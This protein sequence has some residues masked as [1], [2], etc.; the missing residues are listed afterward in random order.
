MTATSPLFNPFPGLRPFREDETHLF[1]GRDVQ[2]DELLAELGRCRFVA[3]M[4]ASGSGKSSL[5]TAGLLPALQGGLSPRL[6]ANWRIASLRPGGDPVRNLARVLVEPE[7]LVR[8]G[9]DETRAVDQTEALLRRSGLG[10]ADL[11]RRDESLRGGRLLVVVDQFEELFRFQDAG[12]RAADGA[13]N[14]AF[15]RLLIEAAADESNVS[16]I[17]TMRSD[18]LG[19]CSQF[20]QLPETINQGLYLVP[21]LTRTQLR[22]AITG[23]V[24]VGGGTIAP[25]LVQRLL[26]DAGADPDQLP[27]L[28]H[29]LMRMWN[30]WTEG[31]TGPGPI[32]L[33][34]Y[35][36]AGGLEHSLAWHAD[37]AYQELA[38]D[39]SRRIAE[40]AFKRLTEL[41]NDGR[42][43]RHPATLD[44]IA[45]VTDATV[46]E[47]RGVIRH[48]EQPG[49]SFVT[50][51]DDGV[52]DISHE[53]LIR[54]WP[55]LRDWVGEEAGSRDTY[56]R[57]ADAA[58]RWRR[59]EAAL[60][61]DPD[62]LL[63]ANWWNDDQP[64]GAWAER[65]GA[66]F[67][68]AADYLDRSRK[69]DRRR[70]ILTW[71]GVAGLGALAV[72]F[73]VL[74][75][76]AIRA[77]EEGDYQERLAVGRQLA[78]VSAVHGPALRTTSILTAVE[79]VRISETDEL[80]LPEAEEALRAAMHDPLGIRLPGQPGQVGHDEDVTTLGFSPDGRWLAT[81]SA[82]DTVLLWNLE[83]TAADPRPLPGHADDVVTLAFSP[84]G[85]WLATGSLDSTAMLWDLEDP[86][87]EPRILDGHT[88]QVTSL[89]FSPDGSWLATG[90]I[91]ETIQLRE[92]D[93]P[94]RVAHVLQTEAG[95]ILCLAF[96]SDG[97]WLAAGTGSG[98]GYLWDMG[99]PGGDREILSG[100]TA[101]VV[102][103]AF[104][105]DGASL[106]TGSRDATVRLWDPAAPANP[107]AVLEQG[108]AVLG[109]TLSSDGRWLAT[110]GDDN[111]ARVWDLQRIRGSS[112]PSLVLDHSGPVERVS[113]SADSR[114]LAT[115]GLGDP[116]RL[117][118][119]DDPNVP[120]VVLAGP[121]TALAFG[122]DD[123]WLAIGSDEGSARL[124][125][126]DR[127]VTQPAALPHDDGVSAVSF[128]PDGRLATGTASNVT[129]LWRLENSSPEPEVLEQTD[130]EGFDSAQVEAIAFSPDGRFLATGSG[131]MMVRL[132]SVEP[133]GSQLLHEQDLDA[134]VNA[135]AFSPDGNWL[136]IAIKDEV[137]LLWD[138]T[139]M[140]FEQLEGHEDEVL[141]VAFSPDGRLLATGGL[142]GEI[143]VWNLE[144]PSDPPEALPSHSQ[145]VTSLAF[146]GEGHHLASGSWDQSVQI[147]EVG[148]QNYG[149][150]ATGQRVNDISLRPDGELLA[151]ASDESQLWDLTAPDPNDPIANPVVLG[152]HTD[153]VDG[154]AFSPDGRWLA[155]GSEDHTV[156]LW[157]QLEELVEL[158]CAS[159][160]RNL[161]QEEAQEIM[162]GAESVSTCEEWPEGS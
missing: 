104:S 19:D 101:A 78:A 155:T 53:S 158:G 156:R 37:E 93:N 106:V 59:G 142:D 55:R 130:V 160:G 92:M 41:G 13:D 153:A 103:L 112:A 25:R 120:P 10:L 74:A 27:V 83:D 161:S 66:T 91:D 71:S 94:D 97:R 9:S 152:E 21:R 39:R 134:G 87:A 132:W 125:R 154:V 47:V 116:A 60:M 49:R 99:H 24:A 162:P 121:V 45:S 72:L 79:A 48:F 58:G 139:A 12:S 123:R 133:S 108:G 129:R 148:T 100:H 86:G 137:V 135:V 26:N 81:G 127:L 90:S 102:A 131:D 124:W 147:W 31:V 75:V 52:V 33:E 54:Q 105:R 22:R 109:L 57:L 140:T 17:L 32:D 65:Y 89:A 63:A 95:F 64:S 69:A 141:S 2:I 150:L 18:Y 61:R 36:A 20:D 107:F 82:D 128:G 76:W 119:V 5:V 30:L 117:F 4:G 96:S 6:G 51:S 11:A 113:F 122:A 8:G 151:V 28:Q 157:F 67:Q 23:P 16:V 14:P 136:G 1:F 34:H 159:A 43:G 29:A 56:L 146:D 88:D 144:D 44:E 80:R 3:V 15:V 115:G 50:V 145:R 7:V 77:G 98:T 110:G 38:D 114:W 70:R 73:T 85:R 35:E 118:R 84:D 126:T 46:D 143:L 42:E 149:T 62:L 40:L 138:V 111:A 68:N